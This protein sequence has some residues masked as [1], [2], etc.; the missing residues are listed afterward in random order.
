L[1][2]IKADDPKLRCY[3]TTPDLLPKSQKQPATALHC[4]TNSYIVLCNTI[5]FFLTPS[6][7]HKIRLYQTIFSPDV[8]QEILAYL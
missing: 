5:R 7:D 8:Q 2:S 4:S 3:H 1:K 6:Q